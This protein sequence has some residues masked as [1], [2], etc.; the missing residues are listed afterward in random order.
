MQSAMDH[1]RG[2]HL[3]T[4]ED[5]D[6]DELMALLR[7]AAELKSD[8]HAHS[9]ALRGRTVLLQFDRPSTRTRLSFEAAVARLGG[10]TSFV[11]GGDAP[12][13][14]R[15]PIRDLAR[16]A[17]RYCAA[18]VLRTGAQATVDEFAS[19]SA[20]PVINGL[21]D[22]HHPVQALADLQTLT[23][24]FGGATGLD[25]AFVGDGG[26]NIA[27]SLIQACALVGAWLRIACPAGHAP[28]PAILAAGQARAADA[29]GQVV[30]L[31]EP[32][33]AVAGVQ[34]VYTD[35]F[36][37]MGEEDRRQEKLATLAPYRVTTELFE[38]AAADAVF[39]HCLPAHRGEEVDDE[40]LEGPRSA[41]WDQAENRLHTAA[42]L[43]VTLLGRGTDGGD[44]DDAF[45][46]DIV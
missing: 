22:R 42:A 39:L 9:V 1:R 17:S 23:E 36:V 3:R 15:E 29:G 37:S 12:L 43:L 7:L 21:T 18:V 27:H 32:R 30:L 40:V 16:V 11:A 38:L 41:V 14:V 6:A 25:L 45:G 33:E 13:G 26:S 19:W 44:D 31:D 34:A 28:D 8:H 10:A 4:L 2:A 24:R 20:V 46:L 35:V 5:L